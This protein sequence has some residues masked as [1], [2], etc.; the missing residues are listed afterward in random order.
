[1]R[2]VET[3]DSTRTIQL[4]EDTLTGEEIRIPGKGAAIQWGKKRGDFIAK[5]LVSDD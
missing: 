2:P 3:V 5:F 1:M 4:E